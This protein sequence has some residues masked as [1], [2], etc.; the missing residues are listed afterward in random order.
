VRIF[1]I[2][3]V[4]GGLAL[5]LSA[6]GLVNSLVPNQTVANPLGINGT[7]VTMTSPPPTA[8]LAPQ[9]T[10]TTFGGAFHG[11]F[12]DIDASKIPS[13]VKPNGFDADI[14]VAATATITTSS[15]GSLPASFDVTEV[16][17]NLTVNDGPTAGGTP[18]FTLTP[19]YDHKGTSLLHFTKTSCTA[20]ECTYSVTQGPDFGSALIALALS[21][22]DVNTLWTIVTSGQPTNYASGVAT[23]TVST[24]LP[25]DAALTVTLVSKDGTL[26]F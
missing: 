21:S 13:G 24:P 14:N 16:T 9:A 1:R 23:V 19:P 3:L 7:Q 2:A 8:G 15:A 25:S 17:L 4:V 20:T 12:S 6:C 26:K 22:S 18:S 5:V 10:A 11:T